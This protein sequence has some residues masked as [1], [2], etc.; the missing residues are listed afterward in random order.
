LL[1]WYILQ[2]VG[3]PAVATIMEFL[4]ADN[5]WD[6]SFSCKM[7]CCSLA[8]MQ[9]AA[10]ESVPYLG[11]VVENNPLCRR[12]ALFIL[13]FIGPVSHPLLIDLLK[14][15]SNEEEQ[16][17]ILLALMMGVVKNSWYAEYK[18]NWDNKTFYINFEPNLDNGMYQVIVPALIN[19]LKRDRQ[20]LW[21]EEIAHK[22]N[23]KAFSFLHELINFIVDI[24]NRNQNDEI[25]QIASFQYLIFL[26][27]Q[28]LPWI[29]SLKRQK[30]TK[31]LAEWALQ[32]IE[33]SDYKGPGILH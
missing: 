30:S 16:K 12:E 8:L 33:K 23:W 13:G 15:A 6:T 22:I 28:S 3:S 32:E 27:E 21:V 18:K 25:T 17:E 10:Y 1:V 26:G 9:T 7:A 5:H 31:R 29:S 20:N 24:I 4:M 14:R 11:N 2:R 19:I